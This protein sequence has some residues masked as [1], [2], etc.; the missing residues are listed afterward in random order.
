MIRRWYRRL[1]HPRTDPERLPGRHRTDAG[2]A[3][4][5]VHLHPMSDPHQGDGP[6]AVVPHEGAQDDER[7]S[8]WLAAL[9]AD[10]AALDPDE[11]AW[12]RAFAELDALLEQA[13]YVS[14]LR[15]EQHAD[16]VAG[17]GWRDAICDRAQCEWCVHD[18]AE[19]T[20]LAGAFALPAVA[21]DWSTGEWPLV[22]AR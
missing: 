3:A 19:A 16:R 11:A 14:Q 12:E 2:P 4:P 20:T 15:V 10:T 18:F 5:A 22:G 21:V 17:H 7:T 8:A 6:A 9:T 13:A 1:R